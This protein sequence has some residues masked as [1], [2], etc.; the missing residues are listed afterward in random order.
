MDYTNETLAIGDSQQNLEILAT[1]GT[2]R[3]T[4][5][6][7]TTAI[8][9]EILSGLKVYPVPARDHITIII[10]Q[11]LFRG[12]YV[13][14][15]MLDL[16]GKNMHIDNEFDLSGGPIT[17]YINTLSDGMYLLEVTDKITTQRVK[18]VK[19]R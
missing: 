19:M 7:L 1:V 4:V 17:L 9:D 18:I 10:P 15:R 12:R 11:A 2:D 3:I 5:Q 14:I 13:R 6:N 8:A 16:S